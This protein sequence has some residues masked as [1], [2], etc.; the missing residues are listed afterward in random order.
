MPRTAAEMAL[1]RAMPR[2]R[3][4]PVTRTRL[5]RCASKEVAR[6]LVIALNATGRYTA[7]HSQLFKDETFLFTDAPDDVLLILAGGGRS[8]V[9]A[10]ITRKR[11]AERRTIALV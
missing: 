7:T 10:S 8:V 11:E 5:T 3:M 6:R 4:Q 2:V 1:L 9:T